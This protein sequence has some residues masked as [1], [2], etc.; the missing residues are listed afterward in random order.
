M[1]HGIEKE[2]SRVCVNKLH[3][4]K[5]FFLL[6]LSNTLHRQTLFFPENTF[7]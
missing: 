3:K 5:E 1:D 7:Y 2:E 4:Y 6:L